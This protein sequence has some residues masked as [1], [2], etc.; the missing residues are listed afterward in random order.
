[1]ISSRV[2]ATA[3]SLFALAACTEQ[4]THLLTGGGD[5]SGGNGTGA[6][7]SQGAGGQSQ[8][9]NT[10]QGGSGQGGDAPQPATFS[11]AA[12]DDAPVLELRD[13][14]D[15]EV[16]VTPNGY[17]GPVLLHVEGLPSDVTADLSTSSVAL[18]GDTTATFTVTLATVSST[19]TGDYPFTIHGTVE[20]GEK[21]GDATLTVEP[22]LTV[23]IPENLQSFS[24]DPP[25]QTAFGDFP[26]IVTAL[27]NM[28]ADNPI[29]VRFFNAGTVPH[30]IHADAG[31][32]GFGHGTGLIDPGTFD[33]VE[34]HVTS[35][36][37][38]G[39]YPHDIGPSILG[40]IDI[41]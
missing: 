39:Y 9:G 1:M 33:P 28:S 6:S 18:D 24:A 38:Y 22:I 36:G 4:P 5:A 14:V 26:T 13:T 11:I 27:P 35:P 25:N 41:Q 16:S 34:R 15:V 40:E 30:E 20:S 8:G 37:Q 3:A 12:A 10:S 2:L 23:I 19:V 7:T 31:A 17:V 32:D 29:T 21:T